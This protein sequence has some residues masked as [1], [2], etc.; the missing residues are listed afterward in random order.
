M[1]NMLRWPV[2]SAYISPTSTVYVEFYTVCLEQEGIGSP[3]QKDLRSAVLA[4]GR[5]Y[6][7]PLTSLV[8]IDTCLPCSL[9]YSYGSV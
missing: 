1:Y 6:L 7:L 3:P 9:I 8:Q 5:Q 2:S 4:E